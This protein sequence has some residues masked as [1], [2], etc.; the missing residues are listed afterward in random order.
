[1]RNTLIGFGVVKYNQASRRPESLVDSD[2]MTSK[3]EA[4]ELR[5]A[6]QRQE[7]RDGGSATFA[8]VEIH[9]RESA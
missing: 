5:G 2:L 6:Y 3:S 9:L 4:V 1:M 7:N 8:V